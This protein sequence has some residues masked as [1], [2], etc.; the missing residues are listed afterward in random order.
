MRVPRSFFI[1]MWLS[2]RVKIL[3]SGGVRRGVAC[4]TRNSRPTG[5]RLH[6]HFK[7]TDASRCVRTK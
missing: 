6:D 7:K 5:R 1:T 3:R 4:Y 2:Q